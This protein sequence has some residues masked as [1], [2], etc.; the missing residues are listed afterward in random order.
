MKSLLNIITAVVLIIISLPVQLVIALIVWLQTKENPIFIQERGLTLTKNRF[1][2]Y[3]YRTIRYQPFSKHYEDKTILCKSSKSL[4]ISSF[5]SFLRK[6]GLDELPQLINIVKGEMALIG[7]RP[8]SLSDL[9][10]L[11]KYNYDLYIRREQLQIKCGITGLWQVMGDRKKGLENLISLDEHYQINRSAKLN[12]L[13]LAVT[14]QTLFTNTHSDAFL[15]ENKTSI[16]S[17]SQES[18]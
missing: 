14:I 16:S 18:I 7:P 15:N 10:L 11:K 2:I 5:C 13:I 3:K 9:E 1:K 8:L 17:A 4:I 12:F 6:S